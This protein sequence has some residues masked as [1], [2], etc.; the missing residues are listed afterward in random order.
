[1]YIENQQFNTLRNNNLQANYIII[2]PD[3]YRDLATPLIELRSPAIFASLEDIYQEFSGG[4]IDPMAIRTFVQWTQENWISPSPMHLL[5]LG[6][7][8]YDYRNIN[9]LSAIVV[10]TIQV[11]SFISYP[12]DD[13]LTTIYGNLPELSIGRFPAKNKSQVESF[14]DKIMFIETSNI[15]GPWRQKL[16]LIADDPAR[17]EPNHGGIATGKSHTLNSETLS[18]I[19]PSIIDVEKIY[20]LEYPEVSDASAYGVTKPAATEALFNSIRNGTAIINYCDRSRDY[21]RICEHKHFDWVKSNHTVITKEYPQKYERGLTPYYPINDKTNQ[22]LYNRYKAK[23][24]ELTNV[25][26]GGRLAEYKYMDMHVV[27]ESA[28]NKFN[29]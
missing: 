15:L 1:L 11:Q 3:I 28:M 2:G 26:F 29:G 19:I 21:T 7:S 14:I 20:M 27:I 5:L 17:P 24:K 8:G 13:R 12:S 18:D 25:L 22:D 16:T 10:P 4:N 6:D 23:S 9:G